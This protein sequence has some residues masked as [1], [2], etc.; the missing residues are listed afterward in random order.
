VHYFGAEDNPYFRAASLYITSAMGG[1][2]MDPGCKADAAIVLIGKQGVGKSTA[3]NALAPMEATFV[4]INLKT[5]DADLSRQLRGKLIGEIAE[6]RGLASRESEDIKAFMS[7]THEKWI[8]KYKEY[9]ISFAR[10]L[11][12]WGSSNEQE[13]LSDHT[14]NRRWLPIEITNPNADLVKQDRDQIWAEAIH[15]FLNNGI[16][17]EEVQKLV[18]EVQTDHTFIDPVQAEIEYWILNKDPNIH[19]TIK[20]FYASTI[21]GGNDPHIELRVSRSIG[22]A[23]TA[24][25]YTSKSQRIDGVVTKV[26]TKDEK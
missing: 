1:R 6:L 19:I 8:P 15:L 21:R 23:L 14:G 25:G 13:F 17:W 9:E 22:R 12:F 20:N 26:Y 2:L 4:E 24:L 16:L 10:R 3:I 7:R 5:R 18:P 11:T